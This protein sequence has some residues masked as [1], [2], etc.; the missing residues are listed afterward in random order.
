MEGKYIIDCFSAKH[1]TETMEKLNVSIYKNSNYEPI[2]IGGGISMGDAWKY[3]TN[4]NK[5][6]IC[7]WKLLLQKR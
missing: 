6:I 4:I 7:Q 3:I 5:E 1:P 2:S